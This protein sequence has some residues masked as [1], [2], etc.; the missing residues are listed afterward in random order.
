MGTICRPLVAIALRALYR[1]VDTDRVY[2]VAFSSPGSGSTYLVRVTGS[3][4]CICRIATDEFRKRLESEY[5]GPDRYEPVSQD[6]FD[7]SILKRSSTRGHV[8]KSDEN[9]RL[10][11]PLVS[12]NSEDSCRTFI[13]IL[14]D[15]HDRA[16]IIAIYAQRQRTSKQ[17]IYRLLRTYL[18]NGMTAAAVSSAFP[19]CG[20]K[21]DPTTWLSGDSKRPS[22]VTETGKRN[23]YGMDIAPRVKKVFKKRPGRRPRLTDVDYILPSAQLDCL[24]QQL[25]DIYIASP[26]GQ[27]ALDLP[28]ALTDA[29]GSDIS[30]NKNNKEGTRQKKMSRVDRLANQKQQARKTRQ[31]R[32]VRSRPTL[33]NLSDHG[34][35]LLRNIPEREVRDRNGEIVSIELDPHNA[36]TPRMIQHYL[37]SNYPWAVRRR[38]AIGDRTFLLTERLISGHALSHVKGPGDVYLIDATIADAYLVSSLDIVQVVARPTIYFIVDL[39]SRMIAGVYVGFE[40]PSVEACAFAL[41]NMVTPKPEFCARYGLRMSYEEWP[42]EYAPAVFHADRGSEFMAVAVWRRVNQELHAEVQNCRPYW[43]TWRSVGERRFGIVPHVMARNACGIVEKDIGERGTRRYPWDALYT[44]PVFIRLLIRAIY[45]YHRTPI[46]DDLPPPE[47]ALA[48]TPLNRWNWG[49]ENVSGPLSRF[50]VD[51][52]R[53]ATW[54]RE[55]ASITRKGILCRNAYYSMPDA[56]RDLLYEGGR[57]SR[58]TEVLCGPR[59]SQIIYQP[60]DTRVVCELA[61]TNRVRLDDVEYEDFKQYLTRQGLLDAQAVSDETASRIIGQLNSQ[62]DT[63]EAS[64]QKKCALKNQGLKHPKTEGA[65]NLRP[66]EADLQHGRHTMTPEGGMQSG[67]LKSAEHPKTREN[68]DQ[69]DTAKLLKEESKKKAMEMLG[70]RGKR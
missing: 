49:I 15:K 39:W 63:E 51:Q 57:G 56:Y 43:P 32:G 53:Q 41:E 3:R 2:R 66:A 28:G 37:H 31:H 6:P 62:R 9:W 33:R 4:L 13:R 60:Y 8:S 68:L 1:H 40:Y 18:Q 69:S 12:L 70:Y 50:S 61:P 44:L 27:W 23:R 42:C 46:R 36:I 24:L 58:D 52:V 19:N 59:M 14:S 21:I 38:R 16:S 20:H 11:E 10:I 5:R 35:Y 47:M 29:G 67:S 54:R 25:C 64:K 22:G 45:T 55:P 34:N 30:N 48:N 17:R 26:L 65:R 7:P